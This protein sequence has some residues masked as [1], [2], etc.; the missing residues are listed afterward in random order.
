MKTFLLCFVAIFS[1]EASSRQMET[2]DH[3]VPIFEAPNRTAKTLLTVPKGRTLECRDRIGI[4]WEVHLKDGRRGYVH[5]LSVRLKT[6]HENPNLSQTLRNNLQV[7]KEGERAAINRARS[8]A[9]SIHDL[10]AHSSVLRTVQDNPPN[11]R[12]VYLI[13]ALKVSKSSIEALGRELGEEIAKKAKGR[14]L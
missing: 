1:L 13:E 12:L 5:F 9:A 7:Q 10:S 8:N 11:F 14:D 4:F 6:T 2:T 3:N